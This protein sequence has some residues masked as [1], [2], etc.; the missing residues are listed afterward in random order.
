MKELTAAIAGRPGLSEFQDRL[1]VV[2]DHVSLIEESI[3]R[4]KQAVAINPRDGLARVNLGLAHYH[5][6]RYDQALAITEEATSL[7]ATAWTFHQ[8]AHCLVRLG[9]LSEA[10]AVVERTSRQ[11]PNDVLFFPLRGIIAAFERDAARARAQIELTIQNKKSFIHY[12]H[13]QNDIACIYALLGER[14]EALRWLADAAHNG[15]P[16][17]RF[18]ETDPLLD[19]I[20]GEERFRS[21]MTELRAECDGY[22]RLYETLRKSASGSSESA[23]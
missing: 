19:S 1:A 20:R 9:K 8:I 12:H 16:C 7:T 13:A 23:A 21:L 11:F 10:A 4:S 2:L 22:R 17:Y 14:E 15:F 18:F 5:L 3:E 6:G